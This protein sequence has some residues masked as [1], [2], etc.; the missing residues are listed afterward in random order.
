MILIVVRSWKEIEITNKLMMTTLKG[1]SD[2]EKYQ[3]KARE[4]LYEKKGL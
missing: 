3:D 2:N 1:T 4:I